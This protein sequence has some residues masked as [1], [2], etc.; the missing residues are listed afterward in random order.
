MLRDT[1]KQLLPVVNTK[2]HMDALEAYA[3][4]RISALHIHLEAAQSMDEV[5][6]LQGR[7]AELKRFHTLRDEVVK[8]LEK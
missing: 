7:I 5:K 3:Q 8:G 4:D 1:M 6:G 2:P